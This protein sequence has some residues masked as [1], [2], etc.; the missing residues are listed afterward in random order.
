MRTLSQ[1]KN[2]DGVHIDVPDVSITIC[3]PW[4]RLQSD[5]NLCDDGWPLLQ[6]QPEEI[7]TQLAWVAIRSG[8]DEDQVQVGFSEC[9]AAGANVD[10]LLALPG[11][12]AKSCP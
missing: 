6:S 4:Y 1:W 10:K 9:T 5:A 2:W 3:E 7:I 8:P 11:N 12:V